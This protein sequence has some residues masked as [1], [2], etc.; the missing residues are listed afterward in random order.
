[1][2]PPTDRLELLL[3]KIYS[4]SSVVNTRSHNRGWSTVTENHFDLWACLP[5]WVR[6]HVLAGV[7]GVIGETEGGEKK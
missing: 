6:P 1:M 7:A 3:E 2:W 5:C 4:V